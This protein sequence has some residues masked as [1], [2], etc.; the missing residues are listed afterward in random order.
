MSDGIASHP[1]ARW[2]YFSDNVENSAQAFDPKLET[3]RVLEE[4]VQKL[5]RT[6]WSRQTSAL[7]PLGECKLSQATPKKNGVYC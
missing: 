4:W 7:L 1:K 2:K 5:S 3:K 6:V